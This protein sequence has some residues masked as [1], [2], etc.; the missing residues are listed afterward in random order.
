MWRRRDRDPKEKVIHHRLATFVILTIRQTSDFR[1]KM[2][3]AGI[4]N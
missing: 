3:S 2:A 4:S 1:V